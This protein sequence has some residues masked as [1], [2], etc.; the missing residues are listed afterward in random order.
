MI[1]LEWQKTIP[2][3][4]L[5]QKLNKSKEAVESVDK[6]LDILQELKE[7]TGYHHPLIETLKQ[8]AEDLGERSK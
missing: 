5:Y 7:R 1:E 4:V 3:L 8:I 2:I 6:G